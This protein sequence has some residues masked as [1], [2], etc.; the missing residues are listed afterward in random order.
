M[1]QTHQQ[2]ESVYAHHRCA[3]ILVCST[4][5]HF[6]SVYERV[7]EKQDLQVAKILIGESSSFS[8]D[9]SGS[10]KNNPECNPIKTPDII[11]EMFANPTINPPVY[12]SAG[13]QQYNNCTVNMFAPPGNTYFPYQPYAPLPMQHTV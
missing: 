3:R 7:T 6:Y 11:P 13:G 2:T 12:P 5:P 10:N 4:H 1:W 9:D 8:V